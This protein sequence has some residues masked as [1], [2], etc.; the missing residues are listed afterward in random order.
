MATSNG[1]GKMAQVK[2]TVHGRHYT[3]ACGDGEEEHLQH[4]AKMVDARASELATA[5]N[6]HEENM[7]LVMTALLIADDLSAAET[8][9]GA[10][11]QEYFTQANPDLKR[12]AQEKLVSV[13][14]NMTKGMHMMAEKVEKLSLADSDEKS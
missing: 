2:V 5:L 10:L 14:D 7:L 1:L 11:E 8:R 3:L 6:L 9:Y 13:M 4:L 12:R